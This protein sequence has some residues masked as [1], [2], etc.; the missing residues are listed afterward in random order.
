MG[1]MKKCSTPVV[2]LNPVDVVS[3]VQKLVLA[4]LSPRKRGAGIRFA[5]WYSES[6]YF[7]SSVGGIMEK[8]KT[9]KMQS[10]LLTI[11]LMVAAFWVSPAAVAAEK[12]MVTDPSTGKMVTAPEYGGTITYGWGGRVGEITDP[13][14]NGLEA[15]WLIN[16]VNERL[17]YGNWALDRETFDL[18]DELVPLFAYRG[19][20]AESWETP[21]P[22]TYIFHIR[23]GVRYALNPDSEASGLV[24]GREFTA[25]DVVFTYQRNMGLGDFTER[26][27]RLGTAHKLPW[28]SVDARDKYTVVMKL[29][30]PVVGGL[31]TILE[32]VQD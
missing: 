27:D 32:S 17:G 26:T 22:L 12:K 15:G 5:Q 21:D 25:N 7:T 18:R 14:F 13:F 1:M 23:Q 19:N 10:L 31:H 3:D 16:G 2:G 8:S 11:T 6:S 28:V 29:S 20:L 24:N 9:R 4:N 30:E